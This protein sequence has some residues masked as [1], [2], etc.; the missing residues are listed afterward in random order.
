MGTR[1]DFSGRVP[2]LLTP[3][4]RDEFLSKI[5]YLRRQKVVKLE[6][7]VKQKRRDDG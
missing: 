1:F 6:K 3:H 5:L 4:H 7:S 2:F